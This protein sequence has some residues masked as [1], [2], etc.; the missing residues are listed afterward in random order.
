M[1][2]QWIGSLPG[3]KNY[4][5]LFRSPLLQSAC[6]VTVA[7]GPRVPA[8]VEMKDITMIGGIR[9]ILASLVVL[10]H[11]WLPTAN[12]LGAH[13]VTA[14]Y[15][16]SGFLMSKVIHEV[17]GLS[18]GGGVAISWAT[19]FCGI[20]PPYLF[21]LV[22]SLVLLWAFPDSFGQTYSDMRFPETIG[23]MFSNITLVNLAYSPEVVIPPAWTLSVEF[24]F[25]IAMVL[26]LARARAI[27][28][29][30]FVTNSSLPDC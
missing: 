22:I 8:I 19:D 29:I 26:L 16:I 30:W 28:V 18:I 17:Y 15:V 21:F 23:A 11:L 2:D 25:Y 4:S 6:K 3:V 7:R 10:N 13:A 24:F 5:T 20:F 1:L 27:A 14:F 9:F 12:K